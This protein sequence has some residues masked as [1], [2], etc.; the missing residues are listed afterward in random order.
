M[1]RL[2]LFA[3]NTWSIMQQYFMEVNNM[4]KVFI[5]VGM[6][7]RDNESVRT[8]I[9]RA[10]EWITDNIRTKDLEEVLI[11]DNYDYQPLDS[12]GRLAC[13]GEAI[14]KLGDCD[15]CYFVKGWQNYKGCK[16]EM[17]VC[18]TYGIKVVEES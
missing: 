14:K 11:V 7:G 9:I 1:L 16:I 2:F 5:S 8:D 12:E 18:K 10:I 15:M 3:L 13:L 4:K 6:R 17:E